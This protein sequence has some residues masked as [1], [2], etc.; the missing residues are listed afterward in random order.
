MGG[1]FLEGGSP[2]EVTLDD[3]HR[4]SRPNLLSLEEATALVAAYF[5]EDHAVNDAERAIKRLGDWVD[6]SLGL[7]EDGTR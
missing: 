7:G 5:G 4:P 1:S 2:P 3:L 6:Q